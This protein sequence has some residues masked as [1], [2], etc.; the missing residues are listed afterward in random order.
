L[1]WIIFAELSGLFAKNAYVLIQEVN[2]LE[3]LNT[4]AVHLLFNCDASFSAFGAWA[5][6]LVI[7]TK[8]LYLSFLP[9]FSFLLSLLHTFHNC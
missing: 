6:F 7:S 2:W 9:Q 5:D 3:I 8:L 1:K 4:E